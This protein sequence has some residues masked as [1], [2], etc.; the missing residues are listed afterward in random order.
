MLLDLGLYVP[1]AAL[2]GVGLWHRRPWASIL[3][4]GASGWFALIT[5]AVAAMSAAMVAND[6]PD[7]TAGQLVLF[8]ALSAVTVAYAAWLHRP[9]LLR[10]MMPGCAR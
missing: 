4:R 9:A 7:A 1:V 6:D 3:H 8:A 10:G 5:I 2:V